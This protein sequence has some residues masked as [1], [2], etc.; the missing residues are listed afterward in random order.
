MK[1]RILSLILSIAMCMSIVGLFASC[2][3][4]TVVATG[5]PANKD[6]LV[7]MSEELDG[8]FNPFYSTTGADST[9][10]SM[11]Q[12]GLL[13]SKY[14]NGEVQVAYGENEAVVTKDYMSNYDPVT[15]TTTYT[16][17]LKNGIKYSDGHPLT[18]EDVLFNLYVYLDPVYAGSATLYSTKI[19]GLTEYRTQQSAS[20][21]GSSADD[22]VTENATNRA[23]SRIEE[24][25]NLYRQVG[26]TPTVGKYYATIA[27][28]TDAKIGRAHV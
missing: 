27:Q 25:I 2:G 6:A 14:V 19:L 13:S 15:K 18:M 1:K 4:D 22:K 26:A 10:V 20:D 9:I 12:I 3:D 16:F 7:I 23:S 8:L 5:I 11:T 28:M 21:S 17:V 24:L